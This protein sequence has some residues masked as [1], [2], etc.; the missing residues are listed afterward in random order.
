MH[1][2]AGSGQNIADSIGSHHPSFHATS[3]WT[4]AGTIV[5]SFTSRS[6][7]SSVNRVNGEGRVV[8]LSLRGCGIVTP[9][10]VHPVRF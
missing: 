5:F 10:A 4:N 7:F 1:E 3:S 2:Q 9:A 8:D 6:S